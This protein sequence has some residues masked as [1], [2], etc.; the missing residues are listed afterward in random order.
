M[1]FEVLTQQGKTYQDEIEYVV[2]KNQEGELAILEDHIPIILYVLEGYLKFVQ[3]KNVSYVVVEQ[4]VIEFKDNLLTVLALE[5]Q[6]GQTLDKANDAF[7]KMKK[8]KLE[9][10]K[11]ENIDF[12]KQERDLKENIKK[13]KAGQL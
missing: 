4:A 12:S 11:K 6:I 7:N 13:S 8:E 5:A 2:I 1:K 9:L 3:D 10:T